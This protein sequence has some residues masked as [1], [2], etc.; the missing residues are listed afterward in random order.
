M[1]VQDQM[2]PHI[3][4]QSAIDGES[5]GPLIAE[6]QAFANSQASTVEWYA[7][8]AG[9]TVTEATNLAPDI[10]LL[11]WSDVPD[12]HQKRVFSGAFENRELLS[13]P[14]FM[15]FPTAATSAVRIRQAK[16]QV[17][18]SRSEAAKI[19][20]DATASE[21]AAQR[22]R[23]QDV[24]RSLTALS[25]CAVAA[26]GYWTQLGQKIANRIGG[27]GYSYDGALFETAVR[28]ASSKPIAL[29][30]Q[31]V[32]LL[33]RRFERFEPSDKTALRVALDRL[34]QALRERDIV[35]SAIDVG[36]ALEVILLHGFGANDRGE[37]RFR[38]SI[39][40]AAFLGG[41]KAE[42]L[43]TFNV[44]KDAY[45]LR[46]RAVHSGRLEKGKRAMEPKQKLE[47]ANSICASIARKVIERGSFPDWD[48]EY[49]IGGA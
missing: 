45:D 44:L 4:V 39:R 10:D 49:V 5:V 47:E 7:A 11:P 20:F 21:V 24:V 25:V 19:A 38:A 18:Y 8:L 14:A 9:V 48:S 28:T 1:A 26:I 15:Q 6:A 35:D 32:V 23:V 33:F 40:G 46:S 29:D 42:R 17:L 36:I 16:R 2:L 34:N 3:L 43:K 27:I 31:S 37:L 41:D 30:G 13:G 22:E 12:S